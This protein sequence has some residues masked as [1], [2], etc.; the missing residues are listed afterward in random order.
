MQEEKKRKKGGSG[1]RKVKKP[2][3]G[4]KKCKYIADEAVEARVEGVEKRKAL[5]SALA[6]K[7][8]A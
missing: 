2:K 8:L 4:R 1:N 3:K 5:C 6:A 7:L